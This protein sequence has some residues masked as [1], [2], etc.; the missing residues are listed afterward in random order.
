MRHCTCDQIVGKVKL[1]LAPFLNEWWGVGL[2]VTARGLTT[3]T[4]PIGPR[5]FE[6]NFDFIDHR[7]DIQVSDG[8]SKS[9][10]LMPRS[11]AD[12]YQ[13]FI[14]ALATLGIGVKISKQP[15][16][17]ENM[18]PFDED[19]VHAAYDP[20]FVTRFWRILVQVNGLLQQYQTH[21]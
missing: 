21:S 11:V 10:P 2:T 7:L 6:V 1:A 18:I 14:A 4:I 3:S 17:V 13:E 8:A 20:A 5:A 16:E 15:V 9:L 12:F 19:R